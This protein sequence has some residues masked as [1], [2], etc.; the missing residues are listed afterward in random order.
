M[1]IRVGIYDFFAYTLPGIFYISVSLFSLI[2]FDVID[3]EIYSLA[4]LSVFSLLILVVA[5][6]F[7]GLL[8]D[9]IA[10][11]WV[12]I[13]LGGNKEARKKA[14]N[15]FHEQHPWLKLDIDSVD[16]SILLH[17]I[18]KNSADIAS[19]VEQHNVASILLRNI[20]LGLVL[21]AMILLLGISLIIVMY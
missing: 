20:S 8:M 13:F 14:F 4:D 15:S 1:S 3:I 19:D 12:R 6:Y 5:G 17:A 2:V 16:W 10:Y 11:R 18:K 7:V 9:Y 21:L